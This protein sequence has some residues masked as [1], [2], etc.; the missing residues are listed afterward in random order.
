M[1]PFSVLI[2]VY[3][4]DNPVDF[5]TAVESVSIKQTVQPNEVLIVVD[6]PVPEPLRQCIIELKEEINY[7]NILWQEKNQGLGK[8]LG[9]GVKSAKYDLI[10]RM[11]SDDISSP[12]RFQKQ[13]AAFE[14]DTDLS[15]LGGYITEFIGDPSNIVG[16][17]E[18]PLSDKE[19]REYMKQRCGLNHV[20]VMFKREEVLRVGN[21][22]DWFYNEDYYLWIRM[23]L[24][25]CKFGNIPDNLVNVRVGLDM[26]SRRGGRKYF[27]SEYGI[28]KLMLKEG[29]ISMPRFLYN[30]S[31][32]FVVQLLLP[33]KVR[34]FIFQKLFRS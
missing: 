9:I 15:I 20:S 16:R 14:K 33:S 26:Y 22:E 34:G 19:I 29:I 5:R 17:R 10:A 30:V 8:A 3:K 1:I 2:S 7:V 23:I 12:D 25:N 24:G 4:N 18:V 31:G 28:Q 13:L 6:G 21:Y 32:R 27:K 11:D